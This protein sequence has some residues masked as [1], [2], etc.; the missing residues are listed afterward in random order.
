[1]GHGD[2]ELGLAL[3]PDS[4]VHVKPETRMRPNVV[5]SFE[6]VLLLLVEAIL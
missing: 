5:L 4:V 1:M 6:V 2:P 3:A